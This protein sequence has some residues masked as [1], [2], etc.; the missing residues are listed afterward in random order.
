MT[1]AKDDPHAFKTRDDV[2]AHLRD[3]HDWT[4]A[5]ATAGMNAAELVTLHRELTELTGRK[6]K[7]AR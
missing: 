3:G 2:V 1:K 4:G 6:H 5:S 7:A